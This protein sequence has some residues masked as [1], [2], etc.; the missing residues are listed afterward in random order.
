MV[1]A[2]RTNR[3]IDLIWL[4]YFDKI[5]NVFKKEDS[6]ELVSFICYTYR[7]CKIV[8]TSNSLVTDAYV[9]VGV[10]G[11]PRA[12]AMHSNMP[13]PIQNIP[14]SNAISA[15]ASNNPSKSKVRPSSALHISAKLFNVTVLAP[16]CTVIP[17]FNAFVSC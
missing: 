6:L 7:S 17:L 5:E 12:S 13:P 10:I 4:F 1:K 9:S 16:I 3:F 15:I 11:M 8:G 14:A 2:N